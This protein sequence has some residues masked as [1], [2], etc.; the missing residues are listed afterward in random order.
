MKSVSYIQRNK[1]RGITNYKK[2]RNEF[3]QASE[4]YF[5][6]SGKP[7]DEQIYGSNIDCGTAVTFPRNYDLSNNASIGEF[8][9]LFNEIDITLRLKDNKSTIPRLQTIEK[10]DELHEGLND[11][12][13]KDL[14]EGTQKAG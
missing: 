7:D 14:K 6:V 8:Y 1:M 2:E 11:M 12:L 10:Q 4:S 13:L 5:Y 9:Q 3:P